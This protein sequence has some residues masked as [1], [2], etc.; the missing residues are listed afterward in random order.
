MLELKNVHANHPFTNCFQTAVWMP[1]GSQR[2]FSNQTKGFPVV[3]F[4]KPIQ[5]NGGY[6]IKISQLHQLEINPIS[7]FVGHDQ[8]H[9]GSD[10]SVEFF[11]IFPLVCHLL[12]HQNFPKHYQCGLKPLG[13]WPGR[14]SQPPHF[15]GEFEFSSPCRGA[16]IVGGFNR[17]QP[18]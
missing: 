11:L 15:G 2:R 14:W 4:L 10:H 5:W 18:C 6:P 9:H 1:T 8:L 12:N 17:C 3:F 7:K 13:R 16:A